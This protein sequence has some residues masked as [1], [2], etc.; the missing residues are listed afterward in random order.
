MEKIKLSA[1]KREITGRK[2]KEL[3]KKGIIPAVLYGKGKKPV[4]LKMDL[5]GFQ[6]VYKKAGTSSLIDLK[7]NNHP[8]TK[9]LIHDLQLH[10]VSNVPIHS[11]LYAIRMDERITTEIPLKFIGVSTAVKDLEG[12][13]ISNYDEIEIEC[14]PGDLVHE[15]VVD[16]SKLKTFEDQI[17]VSQLNI[18]EKIKVLIDP[19]EVVAL[20][21]PPRSEEELEAMEEEAAAEEEKEA[22]EKMEEE[23][24]AEKEAEKEGKEEKKE[25]KFEEK[26]KEGEPK[27]A[28]KK[29]KE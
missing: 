25:G 8:E 18:P 20:V 15:I 2:V 7:I 22:V 10:P 11:D 9:I 24:Q 12:N 1:K 26:Q 4:N 13:F 5:K 17:K 28:E 23:A 6:E 3:R 27:V 16:I 19:E 14:L 29:T 21:T